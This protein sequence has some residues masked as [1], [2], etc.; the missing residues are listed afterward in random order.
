MGAFQAAQSVSLWAMLG[1]GLLAFV[2]PCVLPMLPVYALYLTG[3]GEDGRKPSWGRVALRCAG[4]LCGFVLLFTLM[5]A[6]A[7]ALGS[8]LKSAGRAQLDV[9]CGSL[10]IVFGL[11]TAGVFHPRGVSA[12]GLAAKAGKP[13]GFFSSALFGMALALSWTPCLTPLLSS[14]LIMA[15]NAQQAAEGMLA[16]AVF[17]VGLALPMLAF[18]ALYE[19]LQ[20]TLGWLKTHQALIR[21]IGGVLMAL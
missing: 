16:L 4:L 5:G 14:A 11:W 10:L 20:G 6:G 3:S 13:R 12:P 18:V 19:W 1:A 15:A 17:A 8:L 21:R 2:S 9:V 7:G